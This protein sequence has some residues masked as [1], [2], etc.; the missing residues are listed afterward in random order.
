MSRI[1][2]VLEENN[3]LAKVIESALNEID[4]IANE[5]WD[6]IDIDSVSKPTDYERG[7]YKACRRINRAMQ[8][9]LESEE[10]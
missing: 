10:E 7:M 8:E 1:M 5:I 4:S 6:N 9:A 3:K 2:R